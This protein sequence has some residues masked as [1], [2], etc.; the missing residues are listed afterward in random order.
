[1][2]QL[3]GTVAI[4]DVHM[5]VNFVILV[6]GWDEMGW[7][8]GGNIWSPLNCTAMSS[9]TVKWPRLPPQKNRLHCMA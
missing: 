4:L 1:M 5:L 2:H 8:W 7:G 9:S 3:K 6:A